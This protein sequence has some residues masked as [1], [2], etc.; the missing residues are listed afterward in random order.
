MKMNNTPLTSQQQEL[1]KRLEEIRQKRNAKAAPRQNRKQ[2]TPRRN[3]RAQKREPLPRKQPQK[4]SSPAPSVHR[5]RKMETTQ[6]EIARQEISASRTKR[7]QRTKPSSK[8]RKKNKL[9]K[10]L[11]YAD[12][13]RDAMILTEVVSKPIALRN[14]KR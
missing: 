11:T 5:D 8:N 9:V 6:S 4:S 10:Q 3:E 7:R 12:S 13:L 2:Q 1:K 14:R